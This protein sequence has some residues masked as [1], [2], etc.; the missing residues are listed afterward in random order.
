MNQAESRLDNSSIDLRLQKFAHDWDD[1]NR[2]AETKLRWR[3]LDWWLDSLN[4]KT[5]SMNRNYLR[6]QQFMF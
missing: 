4:C 6:H 2:I 1:W 5:D 3:W